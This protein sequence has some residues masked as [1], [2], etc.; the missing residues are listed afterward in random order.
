MPS[1][2]FGRPPA[3][4][5]ERVGERRRL[6]AELA[7]GRDGRDP[8][9]D[10]RVLAAMATVPRHAFVPEDLQDQAYEDHPLPIGAGQTISQPYIVAYMT[11]ALAVKPG[12]RVLEIG[13]GSGYQTAILAEMGVEVYTVEVIPELSR[14]AESV[15]RSLGLME[16][17]HM[18][19]ADGRHGWAAHAPYDGVLATAAPETIPPALIE[20]MK[21]GARLV[22]PVGK[23]VSQELLV[24]EREADRLREVMALS[25]RFVPLVKPDVEA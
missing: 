20:Q 22:I 15:L 16:R 25:V 14:R 4:F 23:R 19:V 2:L 13:T 3:V 24:L 9:L 6:A 18:R 12:S 17:V 10:R 21:V 5:R 11:A 7:A 8:V 1:R